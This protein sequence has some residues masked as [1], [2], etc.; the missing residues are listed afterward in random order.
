MYVVASLEPSFFQ[1]HLTYGLQ[2]TLA[3]DFPNLVFLLSNLTLHQSLRKY[4]ILSIQDSLQG[5]K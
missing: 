2:F 3:A 4:K 5:G 1:G